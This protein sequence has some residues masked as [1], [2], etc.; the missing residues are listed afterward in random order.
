MGLRG[1]MWAARRQRAA[2]LRR[3]QSRRAPVTAFSFHVCLGPRPPS[4]HILKSACPGGFSHLIFEG[5]DELISK[6]FCI[7]GVFRT[8]NM[9]GEA[10][11]IVGLSH[12]LRDLLKRIGASK[13][14]K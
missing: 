9:S 12:P 14:T 4:A 2:L 5:A 13:S 7:Q 3:P 10:S 8:E 11:R 1:H 6:I